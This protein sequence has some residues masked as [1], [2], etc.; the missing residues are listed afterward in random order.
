[1]SNT[2]LRFH[3]TMRDAFRLWPESCLGIEQPIDPRGTPTERAAGIIL[4][5]V[6]GILLAVS[7]VHWWAT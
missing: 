3:R 7:L 6:I 2:P 4:A 5:V 1:M